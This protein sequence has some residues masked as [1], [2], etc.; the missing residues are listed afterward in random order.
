MFRQGLLH[1]R[2][3]PPLAVDIQ[4]DPSF[5]DRASGFPEVPSPVDGPTSTS[6]DDEVQRRSPSPQPV[7]GPTPA[8]VPTYVHTLQ[9][10]PRIVLRK[11]GLIWVNRVDA[12]VTHWEPTRPYALVH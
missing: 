4:G 3:R 6:R 11:A 1:P 10:A 7:T 9:L 2:Q 5:L 12:P 8:R